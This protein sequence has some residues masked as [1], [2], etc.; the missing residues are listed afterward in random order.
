V[1][2]NVNQLE[3]TI[4]LEWIKKY[5]E[6]NKDQGFKNTKKTIYFTLGTELIREIIK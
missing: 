5:K 6:I 3:K 4:F 2:K 1:L